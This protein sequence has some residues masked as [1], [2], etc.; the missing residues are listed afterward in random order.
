LISALPA[1]IVRPAGETRPSNNLVSNTEM[2]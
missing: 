1:F 2:K